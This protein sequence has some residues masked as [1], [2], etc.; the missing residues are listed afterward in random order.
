[1]EKK[2]GFTV[3]EIV[4]CIVFV[5][6]FIVLFFTQQRNVAMMDRDDQRKTAINA[7]FYALE[8]GYY[9]ENGYY[10]EELDKPEVLPWIDPNL[11]TDPNG[12][13]LWSKDMRSNYSYE[14]S[15]CE[16]GK[17]KSYTLRSTMEKENDYVKTSRN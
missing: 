12:A 15:N 7:M 4:L 3:L 14:A 2:N 8:E 10:P 11:F 6:I 9:K 5:G 17:C 13:N 16:E 1:M